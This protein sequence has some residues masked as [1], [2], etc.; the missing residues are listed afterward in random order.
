MPVGT[1]VGD[2]EGRETAIVKTT[3]D[4]SHEQIP[5]LG[6]EPSGGQRCLHVGGPVRSLALSAGVT[7][8]ELSQDDILLGSAEKP[9]VGV[10]AQGGGLSED[11]ETERLMGP[12][13]WFGRSATD[14]CGDAFAQV[15]GRGP[16][17]RQ[18]QALIGRDPVFVHP[19]DDNLDGGG[20]LARARSAEDAQYPRILI[21]DS[22]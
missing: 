14:P 2:S 17:S 20:R 6:A 7:G 10:P 22:P 4:R 21:A 8:E 16:G 11:T 15:G 13:Q 9:G 3:R 12:C 18:N 19:V 1:T 5:Q